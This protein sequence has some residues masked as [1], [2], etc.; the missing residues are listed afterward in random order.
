M[1]QIF[2]TEF[3]CFTIHDIADLEL[4]LAP[5]EHIEGA[6]HVPAAA[7]EARGG[8]DEGLPSGAGDRDLILEVRV[9]RSLREY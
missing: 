1:G 9:L 5:G 8:E 7:A 4:L 6:R 2:P 3:Y